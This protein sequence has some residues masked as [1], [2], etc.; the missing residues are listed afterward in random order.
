[1]TRRDWRTLRNG[2]LFI[3]PW[4]IGFAVFAL[5]PILSSL[6]YSFTTFDGLDAPSWI[7]LANYQ[8]LFTSDATYH[9][10]VANTLYYVAIFLP[11]STAIALGMALLLNQDRR[12]MALYRTA[13]FIPSIVPL[14][15]SAAVWLWLFNPQYGLLDNLLQ[16][17]GLP[18]NAWLLSPTWV[19]PSLII[20]SLWQVGGSMVIYL[21]GLQQ[22]PM[23]LY[24]AAALDGAGRLAKFWHITIPMVS[25]VIF[26]N[27]VIGLI[28]SF[29][30]FAQAMVLTG[31]EGEP[32]QQ[33]LMYVT[34]LYRNAFALF[35]MGYACAMAW[36]LF[37]VTLLCTVLLFSVGSRFVYYGGQ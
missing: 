33:S 28:G 17:V 10:A 7:G 12:G 4:L 3:S 32:L 8:K 1:M 26:F 11:A 22:V 2:L 18:P 6:Y 9:L 27:V 20:I 14:V 36:V 29:Q 16:L 13:F 24:E 23:A 31:P 34:F 21:A 15:A 19:K 30:Y 25:P 35:S 37:L 5:W